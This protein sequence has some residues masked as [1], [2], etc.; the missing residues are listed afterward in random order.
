MDAQAMEP[1]TTAGPFEARPHPI[2]TIAILLLVFSYSGIFMQM[3]PVS[4]PGI[5]IDWALPATAMASPMALL[6]IGTGVGTVVGGAIADTLGRRRAIAVTLALLGLC[7]GLASLATTPGLLSIPMFLGGL[8]MGAMYASTMALVTEVVPVERRPLVISFT[9]A[10][11]PVGLG[12]CSLAAAFLLPVIGW[13]AFF[14]I[15]ALL[16]LPVLLAFLWRVPESPNFLARM[17]ARQDE[18]RRTIARLGL[19]PEPVDTHA[20]S[21]ARPPLLA[22]LSAVVRAN[23]RSTIGIWGLFCGTYIFG[24]AILSWLPTALTRLGFSLPFA[25]GSLTAWSIASMLGTPLAGWCLYRFGVRR[26]AAASAV[27]GALAGAALALIAT[28]HMTSEIA[29]LAIL[30]LGGIASAGVVTA[31]YTLAAE[32]FPPDVRAKGIGLSD[33][34]GR[35]GGTLAAFSGIHIISGYGA[36]LFFGL[37]AGLMLLVAAYLLWLHPYPAAEE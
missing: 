27:L 29:V 22:R 35:V 32:A 24:N 16:S 30:P 1:G 20:G 4:A 15:A 11:L 37:L 3:L 28:R 2:A 7:L 36:T 14:Q 12:I 33:A 21:A 5:I 34:I 6:L 13:R 17:P 26:A 31:L 8:C 18:Y 9:V 10:S 23:P 25:T 19:V